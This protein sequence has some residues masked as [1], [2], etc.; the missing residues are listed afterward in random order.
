[1]TKR[2]RIGFNTPNKS[3]K[4][5]ARNRTWVVSPNTPY[6]GGGGY[7][8]SPTGRLTYPNSSSNLRVAMP[9]SNTRTKTKTKTKEKWSVDY[10]SGIKYKT[11]PIKYKA[12]KRS[13]FTKMLSQ[14]GS[15][16]F[17][18]ASGAVSGVGVQ[19]AT[20]IAQTLGAD[21]L[22]LHRALNDNVPIGTN[23]A[24]EQLLF[25]GSKDEIEFNNSSPTTIELDIYV[26]I[27]K[28]TQT[29]NT[30]PLVLWD[31]GIVQEQNAVGS[32]PVEG[33][34]T[35][36]DKPTTYKLFNINYWTKRYPVSLTSGEKCKFTLNFRRNRIIDTTYP[37]QFP[38]IRGIT[39]KIMVV[40]RGTMVDDTNAKTLGAAS[41]S[42]TKVIWLYKNTLYGRILSTLP[43]VTQ[44]RGNALATGLAAQWHLDEDTGE[45]ENAAITT[46]FA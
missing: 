23:S 36:W 6:G 37:N 25:T 11:V 2:K 28:V 1:M 15:L 5:V 9:R 4:V 7:P 45:P 20:V 29:T 27:E 39:H 30:D 3:R 13:K 38:N 34:G 42:E 17:V 21:I 14:P 10:N 41:L 8:N 31:A 32:L 12:S 24:A 26:L 35:P 40:Q 16:Y 44:Q 33:R 46:E 22:A 18:N 19:G 43:K